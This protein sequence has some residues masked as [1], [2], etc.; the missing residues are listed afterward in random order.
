MA[1]VAD[2]LNDIQ[3]LQDAMTGKFHDCKEPSE[4]AFVRDLMNFTTIYFFNLLSHATLD[5]LQDRIVPFRHPYADKYYL[6]YR[7]SGLL[8]GCGSSSST[9]QGACASGM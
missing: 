9:T 4:T 1:T 6:M 5:A 3:K 8:Q 2:T 7:Q